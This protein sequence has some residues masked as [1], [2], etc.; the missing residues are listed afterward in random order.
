VNI[1]CFLFITTSETKN[2]FLAIEVFSKPKRWP[3]GFDPL[4]P[5]LLPF[6]MLTCLTKLVRLKE[7]INME[8]NMLSE[9][10][11][12]ELKS[13]TKLVDDQIASITESEGWEI[14]QDNELLH[15]KNRV[16]RS[17]IQ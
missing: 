4:C 5:F 10:L 11:V 14:I 6:D 8:T 2:G 3:S 7:L 9:Q 16:G 13:K 17:S 1:G 15:R 12:V